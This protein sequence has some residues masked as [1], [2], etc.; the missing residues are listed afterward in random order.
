M[1]GSAG[2]PYTLPP[3]L[4][5]GA[6]LGGGELELEWTI[7]RAGATRWQY[8]QKGPGA[9]ALDTAWGAWTDIPDSDGSTTSH[10]LT[11]LLPG[12]R[13]DFQVR[14]WTAHGPGVPYDP[15]HVLTARAD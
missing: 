11:G 8:R 2:H 14:A 6:F 10:R 1:A 15:V 13:Y 12:E 3:K 4:G 9:G 7:A 5:V